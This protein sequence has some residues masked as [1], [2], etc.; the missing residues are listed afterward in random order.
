MEGD[1]DFLTVQVTG[2]VEEV[3]FEQFLGRFELRA[4]TDIRRAFQNLACR[5]DPACHGVDAIT[6]AKIGFDIEIGRRI[7]DFAP[8]LVAMLDDAA[9]G[10][11]AGQ[12]FG[13]GFAIALPQ[14]FADP[15]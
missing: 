10:E 3:R 4:H 9:N 1:F 8:A 14:R 2:K 6:G 12:Q 13:R 15:A 7:A 5:Q 11:G